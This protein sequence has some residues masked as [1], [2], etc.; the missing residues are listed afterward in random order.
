MSKSR[1]RAQ[2]RYRKKSNGAVV[3]EVPTIVRDALGGRADDSL[4][5]EEGCERTVTRASLLGPYFVVRLEPAAVPL[6]AAAE[7]Q[8]A[9]PESFSDAV[10]KKMAGGARGE[11]R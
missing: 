3:A 8:A 4:I 2:A 6:P 10:R 5:F 9:P 7:A 1:V 11:K